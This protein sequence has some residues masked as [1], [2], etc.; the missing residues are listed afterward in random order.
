MKVAGPASAVIAT[1]GRL[2]WRFTS[3]VDIRADLG[4]HLNLLSDSPAYVAK[5]AQE[6]VRRWRTSRIAAGSPHLM[7]PTVD[8]AVRT[9]C[10]RQADTRHEGGQP[11]PS[12][13]IAFADVVGGLLYSRSL[14]NDYGIWQHRYKP[15]LIS[16][17]CGG[18]WPQA[19][20]AS[21]RKWTDDASCQL[22][23]AAPG[24]L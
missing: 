10:M 17:I 13:T 18:Q 12:D 20:L 24:T 7:P 3:A 11:M 19:R 15:S 1:A 8:L 6:A 23:R 22:C 5:E 16:A 21:V 2:G 14:R 4:M 9:A